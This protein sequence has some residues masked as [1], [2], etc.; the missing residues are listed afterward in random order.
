[1]DILDEEQVSKKN[2]GKKIIK[3]LIIIIILLFL[4]TI[5][6]LYAMYYLKSKEF[7]VIVDGVQNSKLTSDD[8]IFD[9][10]TIYVSIKDVA[11]YL[12]NYTYKKGGYKEYS[13]DTTKCYVESNNEV[14]SY[15]SESST[16]YKTI[17]SEGSDNAVTSTY[18]YYTIDEPVK[19]VNNK[20]YT[21]L[22]GISIGCNSMLSY[23]SK[24]NTVKIYTLSYLTSYYTNKI[25]GAA[26]NDE[27]A[28]FSNK[29]AS[30]YNLIVVKDDKGN[31]GVNNINNE[32]V[33]GKKYSYVKFLE[34]SQEFIVKTSEGKMGIISKD[35]TTKIK[36]EYSD[37]MQ[38]DKDLGLYLVSNNNKYGVINENG[39]VIIYLEYEAIGIDTTQF[40]SDN[41]RNKYLLYDNCIPVERGELW[42]LM[43]KNGNTLIEPQYDSLG[44]VIGSSTSKTANN[45]LLIPEYEGI[46][47]CKNKLY[48]LVNS[49]GKELIPVAVS[50]MY[51][52]TTS[53]KNSYY[54]I[55]NKQTLDVLKYLKDTLGLDPV[56]KTTND[57]TNNTV[58]NTVI[59][60]SE[61]NN[62][63]SNN[64]TTSNQTNTTQTNLT[65][66]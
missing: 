5:G 54:L 18:E 15:T 42:G 20:L 56:D 9:G 26:I 3:I 31:Y 34:S 63:I 32:E 4:A 53:G 64:P 46:I 62:E 61:T 1:M 35:G 40:S 16:I 43:D 24:S 59:S 65:N 58:N 27:K 30:L 45:L 49:F 37:I 39:K 33:I 66:N 38:I 22:D 11:P 14:A 7:K 2:K 48:G 60:N 6:I 55:Y 13:E 51:S 36:P 44:C 29:K 10:D 25:S 50:S 17:L 52:I 47:V 41:I 57:T 8:F 23:D 28:L 19:I 21:T 12:G